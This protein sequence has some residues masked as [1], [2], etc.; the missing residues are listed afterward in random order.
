MK[1]LALDVQILS[2]T[3]D[4]AT[5]NDSMVQ[6]LGAGLLPDYIPVNHT[7]CF[8]HIVNLIARSLVKQFDA[9]S[10]SANTDDVDAELLDVAEGLELENAIAAANHDDRL[11]DSDT[12]SEDK[13]D[14][15]VEDLNQD[16]TNIPGPILNDDEQAALDNSTRPVK[17]LLAKVYHSG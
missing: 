6:E 15:G 14:D 17:L 9:P 13:S 5:N 2:I 12:N 8:L 4:N 1:Y 16:N 11:G 10:Q 3:C 7:R